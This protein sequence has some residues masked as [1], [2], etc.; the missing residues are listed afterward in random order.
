M[1]AIGK[2]VLQC[3]LTTH[4]GIFMQLPG[5]DGMNIGFL[6]HGQDSVANRFGGFRGP[7]VPELAREPLSTT[8][9]APGLGVDR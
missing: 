7:V 2:Q 4:H 9:G 3:D 5:I 1:Q 8:V 6:S